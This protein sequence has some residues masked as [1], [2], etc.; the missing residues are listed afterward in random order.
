M[1][2]NIIALGSISVFF[3]FDAVWGGGIES[4]VIGLSA[5]SSVKALDDKDFFGLGSAFSS[6]EKVNIEAVMFCI[7]ENMNNNGAVKVHLVIVYDEKELV[8]EF[9]KMTARE[10][11][12]SIKQLKK[13][14]PD[15]MK[16]FK[17]EFKAEKKMSPW[18]PIKH[19]TSELTPLKGFVFASYDSI[20][21]HRAIIP[22]FCKKMKIT[23]KEKEFEIEQADDEKKESEEAKDDND[24]DEQKDI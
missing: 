14:H 21:E 10:Y 5:A 12:R 9:S 13:D 3:A 15:K 19:N 8:G 18:V 22:S 4:A 24:D 1:K 6:K 20:G 23:M 7:E 2:H 11:F 16:I 17:W